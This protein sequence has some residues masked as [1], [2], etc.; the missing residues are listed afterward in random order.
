MGSEDEAEQSIGRPCRKTNGSACPLSVVVIWSSQSLRR[1]HAQPAPI[2]GRKRGVASRHGAGCVP[3]GLNQIAISAGPKI[4]RE[5]LRAFPLAISG[6]ARGR[7]PGGRAV[8]SPF[9]ARSAAFHAVRRE[10]VPIPTPYSRAIARILLPAP[11]AARIALTLAAS[12]AMAAGLPRPSVLAVL[13][14]IT[15]S[16]LVGA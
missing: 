1:T 7:R 15:S 9:V 6:G 16:Y 10:T 8:A 11:R 5:V 13:R 3:D 4:C 14:L 2:G 12:S